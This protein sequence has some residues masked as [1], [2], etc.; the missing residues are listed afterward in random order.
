MTATTRGRPRP[1]PAGSTSVP[2]SPRRSPHTRRRLV[3]ATLL[4]AALLTMVVVHL[5]L[6]ETWL[7]PS[8]VAA[9]L[10]GQGTSA[11]TDFLVRELRG[12][13]VVGALV[14]GAAL[15]TSGAIT[16]SLLR[17]PLASPDIIGV[18]AGA[19]CLAVVALLA[20]GTVSFAPG[21]GSVG[22]PVL[23]CAGG[24]IAGVLVVALAWRGGLD[25]RRVVLVGLG[26]NAGLS[27]LTS[28]LL[29]RADLPDLTAAMTWLTGS[30]AAVDAGTLRP[31]G[32]SAVACL[33]LALLGSERLGLLRFGDVTVRSLGVN[34]AVSQLIQAALA[35]VAA[36]LACA[37][38]G[39][40][41]FVAFCAPQIAMVLFRTQGPPV[42]GGMLVGAAI[43]VG[44]DIA[45]R[46]AFPT[47]VP[48]GL[49]TAFCGAPVLLWLLTRLGRS[50]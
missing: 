30:L 18:T 1:G 27:A 29:L 34:V 17:N 41:A 21:V 38:A 31:I 43:M 33:A 3:A 49:V 2:T 5:S 23:A 10:L 48:V 42:A 39:P 28:W 19:S 15:G 13:R 20:A 14:V 32:T 36:S 44:A 37:V 26:V 11:G 6:G 7:P 24:A 16:Q 47:P 35:V 9:S 45:A 50:A 22:V 46:V 40:V 12:P 8:D 4:V 25:A